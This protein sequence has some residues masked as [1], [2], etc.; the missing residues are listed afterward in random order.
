VE[1]TD[2]STLPLR[3]QTPPLVA[4]GGRGLAIVDALASHHGVEG[5]PHGKTVWAELSCTR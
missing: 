4:E 3:P 5:H 1:V 2:G